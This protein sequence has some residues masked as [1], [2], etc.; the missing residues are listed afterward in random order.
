MNGRNICV[1][2][3]L[4]CL[5]G[6]VQAGDYFSVMKGIEKTDSV[7]VYNRANLWEYINGAADLFIDYGF[8]ELQSVDV[9]L[10]SLGATVDVYDMGAPLNAFGIYGLERPKDAERLT[11]GTE[12]VIQPPV[13]CLLLKDRYYVKFN[14]FDGKLNTDNGQ[15]LLKRV[16]AGL[17]GEAAYPHEFRLL[18]EENQ[19]KNSYSYVAESFQG[20]DELR[21]CVSAKYSDSGDRIYQYFI[22]QPGKEESVSTVWERFFKLWTISEQNGHQVLFKEIPYKGLVG[23]VLIDDNIYGVTDCPTE[24]V[25]LQRVDSLLNSL[26]E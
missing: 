15:A 9:K 18:P 7:F 6:F 12:A 1:V 14:I 4:F 23:V 26:K 13:Q 2:L 24:A 8:Q 17:P 3:L 16:A 21:N 22:T 11:I 19:I 20:L 25:L 10:D 5:S